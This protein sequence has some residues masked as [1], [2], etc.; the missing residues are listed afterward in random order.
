MRLSRQTNATGKE[1]SLIETWI[2]KS[3]MR[4]PEWAPF[5]MLTKAVAAS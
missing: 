4:A 2:V 1:G 5:G 3:S